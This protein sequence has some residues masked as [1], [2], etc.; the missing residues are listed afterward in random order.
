VNV[1][2]WSPM[3]RAILIGLYA[4][5]WWCTGAYASYLLFRETLQENRRYI[6]QL[7]ESVEALKK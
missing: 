2:D 5:V 7:L 1:L 4:L 6:K 3:F